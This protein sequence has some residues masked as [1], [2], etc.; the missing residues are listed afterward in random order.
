MFMA[1]VAYEINQ[2][3]DCLEYL[4]PL[5]INS[6]DVDIYKIKM[7]SNCCKQIINK[8]RS[9]WLNI[10][11]QEND[12]DFN[13]DDLLIF[14]EYKLSVSS[15]MKL[16]CNEII[17]FINDHIM[18]GITNVDHK[19]LMHQICGDYYRYKAEVCSD[20]IKLENHHK[21]LNEFKSG[22]KLCMQ[23]TVSAN[24]ILYFAVKYAICLEFVHGSNK[25]LLLIKK[26]LSL[27]NQS[28]GSTDEHIHVM[29]NCIT[30]YQQ[31][32]INKIDMKNVL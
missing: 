16:T 19:V 20:K 31:T 30:N 11:K 21:A 29:V 22:W 6:S 3:D 4:I 17:L 28:Y 25:A 1:E 18:S 10:L 5:L 2:Y 13:N 9:A 27:I 15:D 26:A 32:L 7:W 12:S 23:N 24:I 8:K 14:N